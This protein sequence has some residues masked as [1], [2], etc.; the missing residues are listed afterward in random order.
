LAGRPAVPADRRPATADSG[1][2]APVSA[3][4]SQLALASV[5]VLASA[6]LLLSFA[7]V[8]SFKAVTVL[9][10]RDGRYKVLLFASLVSRALNF[11]LVRRGPASSILAA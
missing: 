2:R 6:G 8:G 5:A 11:Q 4:F 7:Y 10:R 3:R 9:L 1:L